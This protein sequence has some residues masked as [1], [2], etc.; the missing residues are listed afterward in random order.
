MNT[1]E[2]LKNVLVQAGA[3][4]VM[5][6][7]AGL[8][9]ASIAII[10]E[11]ILFFRRLGADVRALC[12]GLDGRLRKG[13]ITS[14]ITDLEPVGTVASNVAIA[15]LKLAALGPAAADKA[16]HSA[17]ALER[18]RLERGLTFL[19]TLGNNAPFIGLFGTVIGII[20]A[21]EE[22]GH[23]APGHGAGAAGAVASQ[24]VMTSIAE[25]LVATAVGLFVALPAVA[26]YNY[27]QRRTA[28]LLGE[29]E[30]LS[31]LVLAYL[32]GSTKRRATDGGD[33][34]EAPELQPKVI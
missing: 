22:L 18:S 5:W 30:I 21:F 9:L 19:G 10:V 15:G 29:T 20:G 6:L 24:A 14:A 26:A 4:W 32:A 25:A 23:A 27:F 17:V 11:R 34:V 8:S 28:A 12:E 31:N 33:S 16:M 13:E 7:L 1:V 2:T 3:A